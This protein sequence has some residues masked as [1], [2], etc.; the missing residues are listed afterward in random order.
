MGH[1]DGIAPRHTVDLYKAI[2]VELAWMYDIMY[3]KAQVFD[4]LA[5][6]GL[7][8]H[9]SSLV[10]CLAALLNFTNSNRDGYNTPDIVITFALLGAAFALEVASAFKSSTWVAAYLRESGW[11]WLANAI[12]FARYHLMIIKDGRWSNSVGQFNFASFCAHNAKNKLEGKIAQWIGLR[13]WWDKAR[14]T[15]HA[16][17]SPNLKEFVWCI[18][19]GDKRHMVRIEDASIRRGYWARKFGSLGQVKQLDWRLSLEFHESV[20]IWHIAT[21]T[22]LSNPAV[23][24][25]LA[26][27][28]KEMAEAVNTL[29]NYMMYLL[30]KH[31]DILRVNPD[32]RSLFNKACYCYSDDLR[33]SNWRYNA[34]EHHQRI[35]DYKEGPAEWIGGLDD[36]EHLFNRKKNLCICFPGQ[37]CAGASRQHC[38][39]NARHGEGAHR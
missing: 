23:K 20:L 27:K 37:R 12:L 15:K 3:T 6:G 30:V 9:L 36:D 35:L 24:C 29:S 32:V 25:Q 1:V 33:Y 10:P 18:L 14:C 13:D 38:S 22:F 39:H 5:F 31:P 8:I 34:D 7:V 2:E 16:K 17:L 26:D 21:S 11:D 28:D 19:K 4:Q